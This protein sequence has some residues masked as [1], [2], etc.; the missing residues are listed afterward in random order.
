MKSEGSAPH[1]SE[2]RCSGGCER[3][4]LEAVVSLEV[5]AM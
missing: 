2:L 5:A 3:L 1:T 4:R